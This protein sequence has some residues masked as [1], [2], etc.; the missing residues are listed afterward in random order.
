MI[1]D[2]ISEIANAAQGISTAAEQQMVSVKINYNITT[3]THHGSENLTLSYKVAEDAAKLV[4]SANKISG[5]LLTF[6]V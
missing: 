2:Q 3:I 6:K 5:L 1:F 4:E